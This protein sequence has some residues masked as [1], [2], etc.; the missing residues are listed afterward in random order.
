MRT[1]KR[2]FLL[3]IGILSFGLGSIGTIVPVLPTTPFLLLAGYCF[4]NSSSRFHTWMQGTK[5]YRFYVADYVKTR[6]IPRRRKWRILFNIYLLMGISVGA[7]PVFGVK[8][9]LIGLMVFLTIMLFFVIP[10]K[11]N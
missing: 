2:T 5:I 10:D 3:T 7:A 1:I 8:L 6:S 4:A 11:E 9:I